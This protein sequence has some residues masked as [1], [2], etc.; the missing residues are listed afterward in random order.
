MCL[1]CGERARRR[2]TRRAL[3]V[4]A[5]LLAG[6]PAASRSL[7]AEGVTPPAS[8]PA[9]PAA[10]TPPPE[11]APA[12][13]PGPAV[14]SVSEAKDHIGEEVTVEGRIVATHASPLSTILSFRSDFNGF[15]AVIR[16]SDGG[17]FPSQPEEYYRGRWVRLT[18]RIVENGK[19]LR[20]V[21]T[22][23]RQISIREP[24]ASADA[25][26]PF[27]D[28]E[29][30]TLE[31]LRRLT[32][33]EE[34]LQQIADRLDLILV[35]L[36]EQQPP[37]QPAEPSI[38]PG[39]VPTVPSPPRAAYESLRS[40]KRGMSAADV[41]RLAGAPVFVDIASE[42]GETWYYGAGRSI[43]FNARGRVESLAGFQPH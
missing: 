21:L 41:E 33:I 29:E 30:V 25:P 34:G 11:E 3:A 4:L 27:G 23:P 31:V 38:L 15:A 6:S 19:K 5:T 37:A 8:N 17:A 9:T 22:S 2:Q 12:P 14:I 32:T 20:M 28:S 24:P 7:A 36:S 42:G 1:A 26:R 43:T 18:G 35:A 13:P 16:P 40:L 39:R 10:P